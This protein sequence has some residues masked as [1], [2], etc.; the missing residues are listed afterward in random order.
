MTKAFQNKSVMLTT[1]QPANLRKLL[2][3]AKFEL[4]PTPR[5]PRRVGLFPCGNCKFC[6]LGYVIFATGF[7]VK[8]KDGRTI[9][10]TYNRL[11]SCNSANVLY[12]VICKK[13]PETYLGKTDKTKQRIS[14][15]ASDVRHPANSKCKAC[16]THLLKCSNMVEPFFNFF[17]F[18]YV[19]GA[20]LRHFTERRFI[21]LWKPSLNIQ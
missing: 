16:T 9:T 8:S 18:F 17:P 3:K 5:E 20:A 15:H 6:R 14:K 11:F 12:V 13:C 4:N 21:N 19:E 1:R 10:W 7:S 2:V